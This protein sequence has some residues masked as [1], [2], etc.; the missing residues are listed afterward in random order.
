MSLFYIF[1]PLQ[2]DF[3]T[4]VASRLS[5]VILVKVCNGPALYQDPSCRSVPPLNIFRLTRHSSISLRHRLGCSTLPICVIWVHCVVRNRR[6]VE[7]FG[8]SRDSGDRGIRESVVRMYCS[9]SSVHLRIC[10][11]PPERQRLIPPTLD[12]TAKTPSHERVKV[13][14]F[15]GRK[16]R[17]ERAM[18]IRKD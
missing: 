16:E 12:L 6:E 10:S 11:P 2:V 17:E 1:F 15:F 8:K 13:E 3:I 4:A 5:V 14:G 18:E 7:G 9:P